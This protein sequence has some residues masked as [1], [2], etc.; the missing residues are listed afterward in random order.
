[1]KK[2][3]YLIIAFILF[4][5]QM[6]FAS[7]N[8]TI[9][10][11]ANAIEKGKSVTAT[12]TLSDTAAWN[13]KIE[14]SGAATCSNRQADVTSD[15]KSTTKKFTLEC[16]STQEGKITFKVTGDITSGSG[17]TKDISV[18]K[19]VSVTKGKSSDN[20]LSDL[21]VDGTTVSGFSSSKTSYTLSDNSGTSISISATAND[22]KASITGTG[23]KTLK[24]GKNTFGVTVTAE[25]GSKKTYNIIVT[26]PDP[27]NK[28]NDLKSLSVNPGTIDFNKNTTSYLVKVNHDVNEI[29]I[30]ATADDSKASVSGTGTKALKDYTNEFKVVVKAENESTKT[31]IVKVAREDA[32]GNYGK[33][34]TDNSVKSIS[35]TNYD[36]KFNKDTKKYNILVDEDVNEIEVKVTP[37]DSK[38]TV[39]V[40]NNTDLK[41]GLNKVTV[42]VTAENGDTNEY[43]FNVYKIGEEEKKEEVTP[44]PVPPKE[45]TKEEK[46]D[47]GINIWMIIAG[48]ELLVIIALIV[49]LLKKK[50]DDND[51]FDNHKEE[52]IEVTPTPEST[53]IETPTSVT[54]PP[55]TPSQVNVNPPTGTP[56]DSIIIEPAKKDIDVEDLN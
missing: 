42:K 35:I 56:I 46:K 55:T 40:L 54:T 28:N 14:G 25:N 19:E 44:T 8:A 27:R 16:K 52:H 15:G 17:Q 39:E 23:T 10:T 38:A 33:L 11:S 49:A 43:L 30:N 7:P 12:V 29:T 1:M 18:T 50:K 32:N 2:K 24:Y 53:P 6:V 9:S 37:T 4:I 36:F 51:K 41:P 22:A 45:E 20:T 34:S 21:K 3:Y 13:I 31:Y 26:K 5:P 48:I 47:D